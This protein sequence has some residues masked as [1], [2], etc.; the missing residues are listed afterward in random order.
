MA[1]KK[2]KKKS[3][4]G[5]KCSVCT[6]KDVGEINLLIAQPVSFRSISS[7]FG[8]SHPAV[9]RHA[10]NCLEFDVSAL[11]AEQKIT[12]IINVYDEFCEQLAFAKQL[13]RAAQE[14]LSDASDPLKLSITPKAHEIEVTYF[15][16]NDIETLGTGPNAVER[17]KKKTAMLSVILESIANDWMEPDK[18]KIATIDIRKFALDAI[19]TTD[20]CIDKFAKLGGDYTKE[21]ANP[22]DNLGTARKVVE[23]LIA[24]GKDKKQ[25]VKYASERYGVLEAELISV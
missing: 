3:A 5:R 18:F 1:V 4:V 9:S 15:D 11:V 2:V 6:H 24:D 25:A 16:Y 22:A 12:Q 21:K 7:Q 8:M 19:H 17:P 10:Q 23:N 14:Y 13:R 20:V